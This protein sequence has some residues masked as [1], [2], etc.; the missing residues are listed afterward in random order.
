MYEVGEAHAVGQGPGGQDTRRRPGEQL[1]ICYWP[2][3]VP[4]AS[5]KPPQM[6]MPPLSPIFAHLPKQYFKHT[7][8]GVLSK[9]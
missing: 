9:P 4:C 3:T 1:E 7:A 2:R 5:R 8:F 6:Q